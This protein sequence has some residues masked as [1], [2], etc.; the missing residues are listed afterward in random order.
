MSNHARP[1]PLQ[2]LATLSALLVTVFALPALALRQGGE[3]GEGGGG[4]GG[5]GGEGGGEGG[6]GGGGGGG[7]GEERTFTQADV[8]RIA[9]RE[10]DKGRKAAASK[11][12]EELGV[13]VDEAKRIIAEHRSREEA[14]K[15][16]AQKA[17]EAADAEKAEAAKAREA[18]ARDRYDT[19]VERALLRA[20]VPDAGDKLDRVKRMVTADVDSDDDAIRAD[21]DALKK[22]FPQL[23]EQPKGGGPPPSGDPP[24]HP[25]KPK[26]SDDPMKRGAAR[27]KARFGRPES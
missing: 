27:A 1:K 21:V 9:K 22:E 11:L 4:E 24:G 6:E 3:G 23:F 17:R 18:A 19:R 15:S 16:E 8:T 12:A 2:A 14:E 13:S 5:D 26:G 7:E 20:G 25:P 10:Q